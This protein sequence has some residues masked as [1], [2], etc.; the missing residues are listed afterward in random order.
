MWVR[1][2]HA[3]HD[4][5]PA[6][7]MDSPDSRIFI[8]RISRWFFCEH[9]GF[10]SRRMNPVCRCPRDSTAF[11]AW[12]T[13]PSSAVNGAACSGD[14]P[15]RVETRV[16]LSVLDRSGCRSSAGVNVESTTRRVLSERRWSDQWQVLQHPPSSEARS[17]PQTDRSYPPL[18]RARCA[19]TPGSERAW[20]DVWNSTISDASPFH[21]LRVAEISSDATPRPPRI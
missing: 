18:N 7:K 13:E 12:T 8:I 19:G 11:T 14:R 20:P 5:V 4:C 21:S 17:H 9:I 3:L 15:R 6:Y 1:A 2:M 10:N 16:G